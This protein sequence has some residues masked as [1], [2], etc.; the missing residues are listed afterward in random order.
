[1]CVYLCKHIVR[2]PFIL[3]LT[4]KVNSFRVPSAHVPLSEILGLLVFFSF[5][6]LWF[7]GFFYFKQK[8]FI[9]FLFIFFCSIRYWLDLTPSNV[10]WST[11]DTGWI[12][13][14]LASVF[15]PWVFGSCIFIHKLPQIESAAILNVRKNSWRCVN[16][17]KR[18][19]KNILNS[20]HRF[21]EGCV[22]SCFRD[23]VSVA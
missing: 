5:L 3:E 12:V 20:I 10:I 9:I 19:K 11:A 6:S 8:F 23:A 1:M 13:A 15:D 7:G 4:H 22:H 21:H 16:L 14:S 2:C 18:G 17:Q